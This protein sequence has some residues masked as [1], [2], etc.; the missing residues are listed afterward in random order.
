MRC[1]VLTVLFFILP[2]SRTKAQLNVQL[3]HQLVQHSKDE[4]DRQLSVRN[5]QAI[6]AANEEVNRVETAKLK[7]R[8]RELHSRLQVLGTVLQGVSLGLESGPIVT[9]IIQQQ[10]R[11]MDLFV[12]HP[13]LLSL[14]LEAERD[15]AAKARQ[16]ARYLT[17]LFMH[18]GDLNQMKASDRRMLYGH[19]LQELRAIA[20]ASRGLAEMMVYSAR[21]K[22]LDSRRPF[23]GYR[24]QDKRLVDQILRQLKEFKP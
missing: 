3:L 18:I 20:G 2:F 7:F 13:E 6:T 14:A 15:M 12:V 21:K 8:Y 22:L 10:Q 16:L 23:S 17:G 19:V 9:E 4:Y 11:M 1:A 5:S 24:N